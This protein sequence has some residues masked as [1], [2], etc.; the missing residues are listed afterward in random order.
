MSMTSL[1]SNTSIVSSHECGDGRLKLMMSQTPHRKM[2]RI[3]SLMR[4]KV[5]QDEPASPRVRTDSRRN[6][7]LLAPP[8]ETASH[9]TRDISLLVRQ[10]TYSLVSAIHDG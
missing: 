8:A 5:K 4:P 9:R 10:A 6:R 3:I 1:F 7:L 2:K